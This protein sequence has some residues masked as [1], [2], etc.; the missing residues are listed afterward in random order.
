VVAYCHPQHRSVHLILRTLGFV[1]QG[2]RMYCGRLA[3]LFCIGPDQ[4]RTSCAL[5]HRERRRSAL[6]CTASMATAD[7]VV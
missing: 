5:S 2:Q 4:W 3:S 6:R 7:N 1:E